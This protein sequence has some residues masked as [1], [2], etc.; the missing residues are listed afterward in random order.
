MTSL[1]QKANTCDEEEDKEYKEKTGY[2]I[3]EDLKHKKE[4]LAKIQTAKKAL[5]KRE[6]KLIPRERD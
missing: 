2:E 5:E 4:R 3:P 1:I 6:E